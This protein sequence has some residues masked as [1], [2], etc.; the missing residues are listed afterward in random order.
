MLGIKER[1]VAR[2]ELKQVPSLAGNKTLF[3]KTTRDITAVLGSTMPGTDAATRGS[4]KI[5]V[6]LYGITRD[7]GLTTKVT[8][9]IYSRLGRSEDAE[10]FSPVTH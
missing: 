1:I 8:S 9:S 4:S 3:N 7:P 10:G 5:W 6:G 2:S